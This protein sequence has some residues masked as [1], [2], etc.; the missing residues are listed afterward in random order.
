MKRFEGQLGSQTR[1]IMDLEA[2][3]RRMEDNQRLVNQ[4]FESSSRERE[5][6]VPGRPDFMVSQD[7]GFQYGH[8]SRGNTYP[9]A[10]E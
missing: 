10:E 2:R 8:E 4:K 6:Q 5:W 3:L 7:H 9:V 1:L